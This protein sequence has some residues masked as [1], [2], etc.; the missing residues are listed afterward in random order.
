MIQ[1]KKHSSLKLNLKE[2]INKEF[3]EV[4]RMD[5]KKRLLKRRLEHKRYHSF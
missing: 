4:I 3:Q 2:L 5:R 1:N